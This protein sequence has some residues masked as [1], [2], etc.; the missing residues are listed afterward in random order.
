MPAYLQNRE[1]AKLTRLGD[2][3]ALIL[4]PSETAPM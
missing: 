1:A 3:Q 2:E 4:P